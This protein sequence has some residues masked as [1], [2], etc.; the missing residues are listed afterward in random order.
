MK[1]DNPLLDFG[2]PYIIAEAHEFTNPKNADGAS[3]DTTD[4]TLTGKDIE[5]VADATHVNM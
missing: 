2:K 3:L 4:H 5:Y 1:K